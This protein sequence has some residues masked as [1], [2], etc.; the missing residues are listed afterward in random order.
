[1]SLIRW[2]PFREMLSLREA[3]D[4]LFEESWNYGDKE[5]ARNGKR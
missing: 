2:D 1:M 5:E 3:M 4:R